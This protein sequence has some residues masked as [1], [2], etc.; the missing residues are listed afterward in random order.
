MTENNSDA[1][2]ILFESADGTIELDVTVDVS[3][4]EIWL[5]RK[6]MVVLFD[7]DVKTIGKH[8]SN[9]LKEELDGSSD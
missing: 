5:S 2:I 4:D 6:Q 7:R 8:I 9:A 3:S 1:Q